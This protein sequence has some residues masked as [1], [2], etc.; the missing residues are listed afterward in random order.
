MMAMVVTLMSA[1][2]VVMLPIAFAPLIGA[3][4]V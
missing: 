2:G 1:V 3:A 4:V